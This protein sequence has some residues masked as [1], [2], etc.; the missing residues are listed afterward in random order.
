MGAEKMK[1]YLGAFVVGGI[2]GVI[3]HLLMNLL[4]AI[5]LTMPVFPGGP[6]LA[7]PL[8]VVVFGVIGAILTRGGVYP[9]LMPLGGVGAMLPISGLAF[10]I[11]AGTM[12]NRAAGKSAGKAVAAG[13]G[14][15][16]LVFAVGGAVGIVAAVIVVFIVM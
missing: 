15:P 5:G 6:P 8:T 3:G 11:T 13:A 16:A 10:A 1:G 7:I 2:M 12:G 4:F 9:K 14:G